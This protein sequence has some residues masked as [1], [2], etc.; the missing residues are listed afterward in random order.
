VNKVVVFEDIL[1]RILNIFYGA[2]IFFLIAV[3]LNLIYGVMKLVNLAHTALFAFGAY[4][5]AGTLMKILAGFVELPVGFLIVIPPIAAGLTVLAVS[6]AIS[7]LLTYA[8]R[9]SEDVQLILTFGL[10]LIF[11]DI[12]RGLWGPVPVVS[13]EAYMRSGMF[14]LGGTQY[15]LYNIY[16]MILV[17]GMVIALWLFLHKTRVGMLFRATSMDSEMTSA[18]GADVRKVIIGA[19]LIAGLLAGLGGGLYLPAASAALGMSIE[20]LVYA[21]VIVVIGGLGSFV[22]SLIGSFIVSA[23]R[24]LSLA[25]FPELELALLYVVAI[26]ILLIKPE[27]L[28]GGKGW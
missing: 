11:E 6:G 23:L 5:V 7:P 24:T 28:G 22:G 20:Y 21:F 18:L 26:A 12:F 15:P 13:N 8:A 2:S 4:I 14:S 17:V 10:L 19:I 3:G 25:F 9:K 27:G 16:V 1:I